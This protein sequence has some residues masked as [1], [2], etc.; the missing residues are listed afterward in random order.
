MKQLK[1]SFH[2]ELAIGILLN[3]EELLD[4]KLEL[5]TAIGLAATNEAT[6]KL[7]EKFRG[8][9][10]DAEEAKE[11]GA[12]KKRNSK[13]RRENLQEVHL[14]RSA[15]DIRDPAQNEKDFTETILL[16]ESAPSVHKGE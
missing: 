6:F 1:N 4:D 5:L 15:E 13:K 12:A 2:T 16:T 7:T 14:S 9:V 10:V 11:K 8:I 3:D